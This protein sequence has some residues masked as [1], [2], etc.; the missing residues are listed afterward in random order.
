MAKC[1]VLTGSAV[2]GLSRSLWS[3]TISQIVRTL[4][5]LCKSHKHIIVLVEA[6]KLL[7]TDIIMNNNYSPKLL[8]RPYSQQA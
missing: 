3:S 2:I 7:V 4:L 6:A 8:N 1:K 5:V